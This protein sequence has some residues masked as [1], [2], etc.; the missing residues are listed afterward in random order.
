M[1]GEPAPVVRAA[2]PEDLTAVAAVFLACWRESYA[3]VLPADVIGRYDPDGA[4]DLWRQVV[5]D[6]PADAVVLVAEQPGRGVLGV[7]RIGPDA[8]EPASGH[9]FSLYVHPDTQGLGIGGRL[10]T[11]A[12]HRFREAD[13]HKATL[14]VF[15]ANAA[16]R[17]FYARHGWQPDGA[18]RVEPEYGEPELRLRRVLDDHGGRG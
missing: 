12:E 13:M 9:V 3:E 18:Q 8:D 17:G 16:A 1:S 10:L 4:R 7:L 5:T 6:P 14:W 15:A 11:A 2:R